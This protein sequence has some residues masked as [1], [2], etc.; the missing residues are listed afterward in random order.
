MGELIVYQLLRRPTV[1]RPSVSIFKHLLAQI[2]N[3]ILRLLRMREQNFV[4]NGP[5]HMTKMAALPKYGKNI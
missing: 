2:S 5:G 4:R 3:F 1:V